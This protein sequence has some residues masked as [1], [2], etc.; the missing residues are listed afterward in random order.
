MQKRKDKPSPEEM[1]SK[2][3]LKSADDKWLL[4]WYSSLEG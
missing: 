3:Q 1:G 2:I 4:G